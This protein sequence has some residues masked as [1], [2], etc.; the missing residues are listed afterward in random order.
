M[1]SGNASTFRRFIKEILYSK[2]F[3][4]KKLKEGRIQN[5][6]SGYKSLKDKYIELFEITWEYMKKYILL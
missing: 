6:L 2:F 3:E 1:V 5:L 4:R